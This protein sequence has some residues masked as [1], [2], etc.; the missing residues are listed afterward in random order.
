MTRVLSKIVA[1]CSACAMILFL[2]GCWDYERINDRAEI[3]GVGVDAVKNNPQKLSYTFQ[4]PLFGGPSASGPSTNGSAADKF[5]DFTVD[6][7]GMADA[8]AKAQLTYNRIFYLG[9]LECVILNKHLK[10]DQ[11]MRVISELMRDPSTDKTSYLLF[12]PQSTVD[13]LKLKG[14]EPTAESIDRFFTIA[15]KQNGYTTPTRLW[16]FWTTEYSLG[17]DPHAGLVRI[18]KG[19][20]K[21]Y[22]LIPFRGTKPLPEISSEDALYYNLVNGNSNHV[23]LWVEDGHKAFEIGSIHGYSKLSTSWKGKIPI[24]HADIRLDGILLQ[25]ETLGEQKLTDGEMRRYEEV[26]AQLIQQ[27]CIHSLEVLQKERTDIYGFGECTVY[28]QP[29]TKRIV[30][31]HWTDLFAHGIPDI[32]VRVAIDR[33]GSIM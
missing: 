19:R 31:Q 12:S 3:I 14:E 18:E 29:L 22:G 10:E 1:L 9:N 17:H 6:A 21:M 11:I 15:A 23:A 13:V 32:Q 4:V 30:Q 5:L 33:K 20:L 28:H 24:L 25:D 7:Q 26:A 27:K 2:P 8:M 16:E